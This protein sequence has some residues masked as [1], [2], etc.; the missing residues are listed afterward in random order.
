MYERE[1]PTKSVAVLSFPGPI[2]GE[3]CDSNAFVKTTWPQPTLPGQNL[4]LLTCSLSMEDAIKGSTHVVVS[5]PWAGQKFS[6]RT[7]DPRA[8]DVFEDILE[9]M[10]RFDVLNLIVIT[11][12]CVRL[13]DEIGSEHPNVA[14]QR[15]ILL[16]TYGDIIE[17][18]ETQ[19]RAATEAELR[20]TIVRVP[21]VDFRDTRKIAFSA[22]PPAP[23]EKI[24]E[25]DLG[26]MVAQEIKSEK[27]S[28]INP[29]LIAQNPNR[30]S[31]NKPW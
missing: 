22:K 18:L 24:G 3:L 26:Y 19:I 2:L 25:R 16:P 4:D 6:I 7:I 8:P 9:S 13:P 15:R 12:G 30:I 29:Y 21:L 5:T 11:D 31:E 10:I 27:W 1:K 28:L 20:T 14:S 17:A 23:G